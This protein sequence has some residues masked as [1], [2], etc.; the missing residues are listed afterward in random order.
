[1][2]REHDPVD[3]IAQAV[4]D[5]AP[6]EWESLGISDHR[7]EGLKRLAAVGA[8]FQSAGRELNGSGGGAGDGRD[9]LFVWGHLE[10]LERIGG[11]SFGEVYRAWDPVLEREV[12]LK[13]WRW[14]AHAH[15][16]ASRRFLREARL[17]ARIRHPNVV[18]VHGADVHDGRM[19]LWTALVKGR[20]LE[21]RLETEGLFGAEEAAV[22]GIDLCRALAAVHAA[23]LVHGDVKTSNVMREQGGRIVLMDFGAGFETEND[24]GGPPCGTPLAMAPEVLRGSPQSPASDLYSLGAL[25]YRLV[26]GRYPL[27]GASL[28]KLL[29]APGEHE[30]APLTDERPDIPA[31]FRDVVEKALAPEPEH[32]PHSAGAMER[33]LVRSVVSLSGGVSQHRPRTRLLMAAG[34]VAA[35]AALAAGLLHLAGTRRTA[36][37]LSSVRTLAVTPLHSGQGPDEAPFLGSSLALDLGERLKLLPGFR[38]VAIPAGAGREPTPRE[39]MA[40]GREIGIRAVVTGTARS[41][42]DRIHIGL[43][44]LDAGTGRPLWDTRCTGTAA[45]Q[46]EMEDTLLQRLARALG[47]PDSPALREAIGWRPPLPPAAHR[48]RLRGLALSRQC[49]VDALDG[50]IAAFEKAILMEQDFAPLRVELA[51]TLVARTMADPPPREPSSLWNRASNAASAALELDPDLPAAHD[52]MGTIALRHEWDWPRAAREFREA[53]AF[54][55]N[56]VSARLHLAELHS[57]LGRHEEAVAIV[58]EALA[59]DPGNAAVR[60]MAGRVFLEAGRF[61]DAVDHLRRALEIDPARPRAYEILASVYEEL[62]Q[63]EEAV[64]QWQNGINLAV[65]DPAGLESLGRAYM[66]S[67]MA[68]VWSWR[69]DRLENRAAQGLVQPADLAQAHAALG[70]REQALEWLAQA[71]HRHDQRLLILKDEPAFGQ[72][73]SE[74][75]HRALLATLDLGTPLPPPGTTPPTLTAATGLYRVREGRPEALDN[76]SRVG[77]GDSIFLGFACPET[78]FVYV[79]NE[80]R[81]GERF[82]L[83]PIPGLDPA[84]PL[85]AN[86]RHRLPGSGGGIDRSWLVTSSGERETI[87]VVA[88]RER[89][90][91]LE[92]ELRTLRAAEA[93][94]PVV[95]FPDSRPGRTVLRG[96]GGLEH[97]P[98]PGD[99]L[100]GDHLTLL[101][102]KLAER[103]AGGGVWIRE[104]VLVSS[105]P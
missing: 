87:L 90:P 74:P 104:Y 53:L 65:P 62:G 31:P 71:V 21:E 7:I 51:R 9:T 27:E 76:G 82:V 29:E 72:L 44:V 84:N 103:A 56:D 67:G 34:A 75:R 59:L 40:L 50:A 88:A 78:V 3:E 20:T 94:Q 41:D 8:A 36:P 89:V 55:P 47:V 10:V 23:G 63:V 39:V 73:R 61:G 69:L 33:A 102:A 64:A 6:V 92:Q 13:L 98:K 25:L 66:S 58:R 15:H 43:Q 37:D 32:R 24:T 19:G 80:D 49:T 57:V 77:P 14:P 100:Q 4:A 101:A 54:D 16:P 12:A 93:V 35:A 60:T 22:I 30:P 97:D 52:V 83:F 48:A 86:R 70:H 38:V 85:P 105:G 17:L 26:T 45:R 81:R 96:I 99:Q 95:R 18:T 11:G 42:G 1:M 2:T 68:G 28:E 91:E 5:R 46:Y 79:L